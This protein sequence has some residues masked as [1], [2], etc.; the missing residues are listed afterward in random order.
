MD[1]T[2]SM[3]TVTAGTAAPGRRP[4]AGAVLLTGR[5]ADHDRP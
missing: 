2:G 1:T 4:D 3:I 5:D